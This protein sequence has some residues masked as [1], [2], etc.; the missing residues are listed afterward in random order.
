MYPTKGRARADS[1]VSLSTL[2]YDD[3]NL[4][5]FS[6]SIALPSHLNLLANAYDIPEADVIHLAWA[7]VLKSF[8]GTPSVCWSTVDY[9]KQSTERSAHGM[10]WELLELDES[11]TIISL[12]QRWN[13]PS[14]HRY[15]SHDQLPEDTQQ[16][17]TNVMVVV[18]RHLGFD[19]LSP[20]GSQVC[21]AP[22]P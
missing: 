6:A 22:V 13:D 15:L 11:H 14:V 5:D 10:K 16:I 12:L 7:I 20:I 3:R 17:P 2:L 8:L 4:P 18:K 19:N 9:R 1:G 21:E